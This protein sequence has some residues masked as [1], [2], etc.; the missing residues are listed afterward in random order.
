MTTT[1][2]QL[3]CEPGEDGARTVRREINISVRYSIGD[4]HGYANGRP[5]KRGYS[6]HVSPDGLRDEVDSGGQK[7]TMRISTPMHGYRN[8][9]LEV[10][11]QSDKSERTAANLATHSE[12]LPVMISRTLEESGFKLSTKGG[13]QLSELLK[14]PA[15]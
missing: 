13:E 4:P 6:V 2:A 3:E 15:V 1:I 8:F 11:R 9:I 5:Q 7:Y 12:Y 14:K 10:T